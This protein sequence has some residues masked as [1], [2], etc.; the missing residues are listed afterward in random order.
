MICVNVAVTD[1]AA[2]MLTVQ[3][4]VPV[5]APPQPVKLKP[6]A[7]V[8]VRGTEAPEASVDAQVPVLPVLQLIA[9]LLTLPLLEMVPLAML[10]LPVTEVVRP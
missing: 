10:P 1:L 7:G 2:D 5:Q 6:A 9:L 8:A 4:P 3:L